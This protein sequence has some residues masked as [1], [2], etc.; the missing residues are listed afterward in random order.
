M[1]KKPFVAITDKLNFSTFEREFFIDSLYEA[2]VLDLKTNTLV[3]A[4]DLKRALPFALYLSLHKKLESFTKAKLTLSISTQDV[5]LEPADL[6]AYIRHILARHLSEERIK[7]ILITV[8]EDTVIFLVDH[9][10]IQD[11]VSP[12]PTDQNAEHS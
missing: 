1:S 4:L 7:Q 2:P 9:D 10:E 11:L 12:A 5:D 8:E 6:I 3:L